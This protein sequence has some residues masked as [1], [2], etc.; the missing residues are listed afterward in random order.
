MRLCG[1]PETENQIFPPDSTASASISALDGS[2]SWPGVH[3]TWNDPGAA[4]A[5]IVSPA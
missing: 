5:K 4:L 2:P 3:W 1:A